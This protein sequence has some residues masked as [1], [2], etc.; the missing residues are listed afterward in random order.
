MQCAQVISHL[1]AYI[2]GAIG[3][4]E[5]Q[6]IERH[7]ERCEACRTEERSRRHIAEF[8]GAAAVPDLPLGFHAQ[9][10]AAAARFAASNRE[11]VSGAILHPLQWWRT[12]SAGLRA[13]AFAAV[14]L[15]IVCGMILASG[16]AHLP[17]GLLAPEITTDPRVYGQDYLGESPEGSLSEAYLTLVFASADWED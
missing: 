17:G 12:A 4:V 11:T 1:D 13:S 6:A 8:L 9:V 7:I 3:L 10:M 15:G 5:A 14:V 2:S 16:T